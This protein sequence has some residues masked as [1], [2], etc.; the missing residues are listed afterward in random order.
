V[1]NGVCDG[2]WTPAWNLTRATLVDLDGGTT[3]YWQARAINAAGVSFAEGSSGEYWSFTTEVRLLT[4][5]I[6]LSGNLDFGSIP[7]ENTA[8]R[9][10]IISNSGNA[11][12]TV[13]G[14][15]YPTGFF[16][17]WSGTIAPGGSR[18][19]MVTFAPGAQGGYIG[20]VRVIADETDG[21]NSILASGTALPV[22]RIIGL[23]GDLAFGSVQV[24]TSAT[25]TLTISNRG[26][27]AL[28]VGFLGLPDGFSGSW[29]GSISPGASQTVTITF[30]PTIATT[31]NGIISVSSN[32]TFGSNLLP[33]TGI[34]TPASGLQML[35]QHL[36]NG[37]LEAWYV[38]GDRVTAEL[39]VSIGR[40]A[41]LNWRVVGAGDLNGDG[42]PDIVWRHAVDGWVAVWFMYGNAVVS[43]AW[44]SIDRVADSNWN[45]RAVG[46]VNGDGTADLIWQ[47]VREGWIAA[48]L[49]RGS[50]VISTSYLSINRVADSD[51]QIA[52]A[53]DT[54]GDRAADIIWQHRTQGW[55]AVWYLNGA[56]VIG[57]QLL[58]I[59]RMTDPTWH[60]RA[61]GDANG[62]GRADLLWQNDSRGALGVWFLNGGS[63][64]GTA[65]LSRP[66]AD[67][68]W[69]VVG[70]G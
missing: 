57:T 50:Q 59:Q 44:L 53:G 63:V 40:V 7:F 6:G 65:T 4:R 41:D 32:S 28:R 17:S 61:V 48:W 56:Q 66:R 16:G 46:D 43:T 36:A 33:V 37:S 8:T 1:D 26:D 15:A 54:N 22:T 13:S 39:P 2:V 20:T 55:L 34:G 67:V 52:G 35:W 11:D 24:G 70:P 58:S 18:S 69:R 64:T 30:A 23:S 21:T 3:Y 19:V 12:L 29:S 62:D 45:I 49:M 38:Q 27:T 47:H 51:W 14:I 42:W 68:S 5:I 31:Y 60:I 10:L 25:R 9:T